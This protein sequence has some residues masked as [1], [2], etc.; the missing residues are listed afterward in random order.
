VTDASGRV[1]RE[2]SEDIRDMNF[3]MR[4]TI[5]ASDPLHYEKDIL[6]DWARSKLRGL[7]A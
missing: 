1:V 4:L 5:D 7:K 6:D 2:G 3:Q